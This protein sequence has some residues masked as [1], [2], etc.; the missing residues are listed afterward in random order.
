[1][2]AQSERLSIEQRAHFGAIRAM[3]RAM[4]PRKNGRRLNSDSAPGTD[5][6]SQCMSGADLRME[7]ESGALRFG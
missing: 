6:A 4:R 3:G 5:Y 2:A 7:Q 1:L